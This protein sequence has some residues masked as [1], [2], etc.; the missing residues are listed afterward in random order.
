MVPDDCPPWIDP[1]NAFRL[2]VR[3]GRYKA[4]L[5]YGS[6]D[7]VDQEHELWLDLRS[8]YSLHLLEQDLAAKMIW[9]IVVWGLDAKTNSEWRVTSDSGLQEM[10]DARLDVRVMYLAVEVVEKDGYKKDETFA[11]ATSTA[12]CTSAVTN[13]DNNE[14]FGTNETQQPIPHPRAFLAID[15]DTPFRYSRELDGDA[16]YLVDEDKVFEAMGFKSGDVEAD[17]ET[18]QE[19]PIPVVPNDIRDDMKEASGH[20]GG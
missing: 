5:D 14:E 8:G 13:G 20:G 1:G 17:E 4:N 19:I 7:I 11:P 3:C 6:V 2:I 9:D 10:I 18:P 15:R 12:P 16:T